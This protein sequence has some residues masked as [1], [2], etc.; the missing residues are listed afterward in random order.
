[1][2]TTWVEL[3]REALLHNVRALRALTCPARFMAVVKGNAY[4]H[5]MTEIARAIEPEVDWF[6]VNSL[7]EAQ[8]LARAGCARPVLIMGAT[9]PQRLGEVVAGGFRQVV[10]DRTTA[11]ALAAAARAAG[12]VA[13]VHL[14]AETGTNRLGARCEALIALAAFV[15]GQPSLALEG[16]YTHYAN[17]EDTLDG[18]FAEYQ[19]RRFHEAIAAIETGGAIPLKHS[20][21]TAAS[22]LYRQTYFDMV[23][24]GVGLYGLWPSAETREAARRAE[25]ALELRPVLTWKA[26]VVHLNDVPFGETVGYGCTYVA[27]RPRRIAVLP[28]GYYEGLDRSLSNRGRVLVRGAVAP[29]VGRV[30]MNMCMVDVTDIPAVTVG[31][32]AVIIGRQG[33]REHTAE[34]MATLLETINYEVVTRISPTV[35]RVWR[36]APSPAR[37]VEAVTGHG[38]ASSPPQKRGLG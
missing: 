26:R 29:I 9:P 38:A 17:V 7:D 23:R 30:A 11:E 14:K 34:D 16:V 5:G 8:G 4:G 20:A 35:P 15:R 33:E 25:I 1:M 19:L 24:V 21:A 2:Y 10:Y 36:E 32:E 3:D 22:I 31:D 12:V 28:V 18:S 27:T 13:P 37:E 6:G